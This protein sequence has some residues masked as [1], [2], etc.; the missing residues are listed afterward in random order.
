M[1][2]D[3]IIKV[4]THE[5]RHPA[6]EGK[7]TLSP[8]WDTCNAPLRKLQLTR[9]AFRGQDFFLHYRDKSYSFTDCTS[10]VLTK[11]LGL[12][13]VL[14]ADHHFRQAGFVPLLKSK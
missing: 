1:R 14:T 13:E 6:W 3:R 4:G 10:F 9:R 8:N 11:E 2:P 7:A 12:R 5:A